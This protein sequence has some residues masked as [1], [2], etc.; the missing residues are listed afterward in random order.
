MDKV[1]R[2]AFYRILKALMHIL[3]RK[4]VAFKD[5]SQ[6]AKQ[7]YVDVVA[8]ELQAAGERPTA[9]RM[10]AVT[11][12]TRKD[13]AQLKQ[14]GAV[15][16]AVPPNRSQRIVQAW[17]NDAAFQDAAGEPRILPFRGE[18]G[19]FEALVKQYSGDMS[20][21]AMLDEMKRIQMVTEQAGQVQLL[22]KVYIPHGDEQ[23]K[24]ALL[25][26]DVA[27]LIDTIEHNLTVVHASELRYQRKVSYDRIP[28]SVLPEFQAFAS[29]EAQALLVRFNDWLAVH[30]RDSN[31][32]TQGQGR[33]RQAGFAMYYFE[34]ASRQ[35]V[36]HEK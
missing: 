23:E 5:F 21:F 15:N 6:L 13:I 12:L 17:V 27:L 2:Q 4:G 9:T 31:P 18:T 22:N 26:S 29:Q 28:D 33:D 1:L 25:G 10:A 8:I 24:L 35:E 34:Q 20:C 30:D 7:A 36:D 3:Y 16:Q 14:D 32:Q 19:S 11:G